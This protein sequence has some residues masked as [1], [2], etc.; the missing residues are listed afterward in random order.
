M[1]VEITQIHNTY[2]I[3]DLDNNK[4]VWVTS[5][6]FALFLAIII[7]GWDIQ[8]QTEDEDET[9]WQDEESQK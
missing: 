2:Y 4:E 3:Y 1:K 6:R 5:N 7:N 8:K 9:A